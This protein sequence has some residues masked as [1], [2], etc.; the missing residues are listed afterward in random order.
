MFG[1]PSFDG[2]SAFGEEGWDLGLV[3]RKLDYSKAAAR[4]LFLEL[5]YY[6]I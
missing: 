5:R 4:I 1:F 3:G 2:F 6:F